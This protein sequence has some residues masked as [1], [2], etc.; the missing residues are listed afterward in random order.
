[1]DIFERTLFA[2]R[3]RSIKEILLLRLSGVIA[4]SLI[5]VAYA[6]MRD[7][8]WAMVYVDILIV[9]VMSLLFLFVYFGRRV[10]TAGVFLAFG[11]VAAALMTTLLL[12]P[13]QVLWAYP[14]LIVAFFMLD[15]R[16]ATI[17]CTGF[18]LCFLAMVWRGLTIL[19]LTKICLTLV[20]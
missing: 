18:V 4:I 17:L 8:Q 9:C 13:D 20:L 1:M 5:P 6:R 11:F 16:Q 14:A 15:A 7:S 10:R 19:N 2:S 3:Q 12:G